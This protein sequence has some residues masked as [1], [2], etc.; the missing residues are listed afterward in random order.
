MFSL[1]PPPYSVDVSIVIQSVKV[2]HTFKLD[3][4]AIELAIEDAGFDI[5]PATSLHDSFVEAGEKILYNGVSTLFTPKQEKHLAQ[6]S[7]CQSA[8]AQTCDTTEPTLSKGT[9]SDSRA[10]VQ[11]EDPA[12]LSLSV[13]GMTCTACSNTLTR[14]LSEV[15]GVTDTGVDF[16]G[17]SARVVVESQK[18]T[19]VVIETIE[20]AGFDAEVVKVEP[21]VKAQ[22]QETPTRTISLKVDGM[23]CE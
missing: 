20:G 10:S 21:L 4:R 15:D 2:R 3:K 23:Y 6:C 8:E 14:L 18:L 11:E 22:A 17:H 7:V 19:A 9:P 5:E 16:M 12:V 13:G 1:D